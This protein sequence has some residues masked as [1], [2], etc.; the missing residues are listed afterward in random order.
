MAGMSPT[1]RRS[2]KPKA[3]A[4]AVSIADYYRWRFTRSGAADPGSPRPSTEDY[5][6]Y[7][8]GA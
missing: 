7:A 8:A 5:L 3:V 2:R 6:R 4:P 1:R